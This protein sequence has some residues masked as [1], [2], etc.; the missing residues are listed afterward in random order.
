L[1]IN[2]FGGSQVAQIEGVLTNFRMPEVVAVGIGG[3]T[4]VRF[5]DGK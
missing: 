2:R 5:K 3:G 1:L 4:I